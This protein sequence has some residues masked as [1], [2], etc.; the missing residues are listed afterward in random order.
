MITNLSASSTYVSLLRSA[1]LWLSSAYEVNIVR[2]KYCS[3]TCYEKC[4][5]FEGV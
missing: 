2:C 1:R 3:Q 4:E 5:I